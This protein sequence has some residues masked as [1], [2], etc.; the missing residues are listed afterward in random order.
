MHHLDCVLILPTSAPVEVYE[1]HVNSRWQAMPPSKPC[2]FNVYSTCIDEIPLHSFLRAIE[3]PE[4]CVVP[5][6]AGENWQQMDAR[7]QTY[8]KLN[9]CM[10]VERSG[11]FQCILSNGN[12]SLPMTW[13]FCTINAQNYAM[14][15]HHLAHRQWAIYSRYYSI[16]VEAAV[17]AQDPLRS[18]R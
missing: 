13:E 16:L 11:W 18:F 7:I 15:G 6:V 17:R 12:E 4:Y 1:L 2:K 9:S 5:F 8:F 10:V 14:I 3:E